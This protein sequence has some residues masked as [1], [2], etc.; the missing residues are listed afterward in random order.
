M[1]EE[2]KDMHASVFGGFCRTGIK[3]VEE[4]FMVIARGAHV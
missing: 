1:N 3:L 2:L 4:S